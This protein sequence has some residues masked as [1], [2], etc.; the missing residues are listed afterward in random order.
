MLFLLV[1]EAM[2]PKHP[3]VYP[4]ELAS[5]VRAIIRDSAIRILPVVNEDKKLLGKVSRRDLMAISSNL[6]TIRAQGI[7]T[8]ARYVAN[9][10]DELP[11][12]VKRMLEVDVWYAPVITSSDDRTYLGVL[13]LEQFIDQAVRH[14]P[15]KLTKNVAEVMTEKVAVA[16]WEDEVD[17]IWRMMQQRRYSGLP[18]VKKGVLMGMV[19]QRDLLDK[20]YAFPNFEASKGR[21][22][23]PP[24]IKDLYQPNVMAVF[25]DT[26]ILQA[27]KIIV[28]KDVGRVPVKDEKTGTL[29]G[30]IDREDVAKLLIK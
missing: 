4:D 14:S 13:G 12:T 11:S 24:K 3:Y 21:F 26:K 5:K 29:M 8:P 15:E 19:T 16:D 1:K 20:G 17:N 7:M 10:N 9:V 2:N 25:P 18:V 23:N 28:S 27:A 6:T 22:S 30:I